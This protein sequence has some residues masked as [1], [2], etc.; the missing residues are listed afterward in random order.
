[1]TGFERRRGSERK[2][3]GVQRASEALGARGGV[4]GVGT[5]VEKSDRPRNASAEEW[6]GALY[7]QQAPR[8]SY[9]WM[10]KRRLRQAARR[11]F[12]LLY[13]T[14]NEGRSAFWRRWDT[15]RG[16]SSA[17]IPVRVVDMPHIW[18]QVDSTPA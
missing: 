2:V 16:Q 8:I 5:V 17:R 6:R 12:R 14:Q 7:C 4:G 3:V 9:S 11:L 15:R 1:M 10:T 18:L 13:S